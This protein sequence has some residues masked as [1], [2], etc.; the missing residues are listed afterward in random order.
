M[1]KYKFRIVTDNW[2]GYSIEI[3]YPLWPF[4]DVLGYHR[5]YSTSNEALEGLEALKKIYNF[6]KRVIYEI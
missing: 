1:F 3:K 4:W 6:E 5:S 2:M